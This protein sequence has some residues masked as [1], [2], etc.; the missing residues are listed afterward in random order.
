MKFKNKVVL[1]TGGG[2]GIGQETAYLYAAQGGKVVIA[3]INEKGSK[4]TVQHIKDNGGVAFFIKTNVADADQVKSL[5]DTI[6]VK[7]GRLDIAINNAGIGGDM[8]RTHEASLEDWDK[9]MAVNTSGVFYCM[10]YELQ[11]M[12]AQGGGAIVN[13]ASVAGLKGLPN[14]VAYTASK[15]AVVGMTKTVAVEYAR[16]NIRVNAICPVFT[17]TALFQPEVFDQYKPGISDKLK[18]SIPMKRF[19]K[20]SETAEAILWLTSDASSFI[21]GHALPVD[22][23]LMA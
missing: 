8:A 23:G 16:K 6:A 7:F 2:S 21:T 20:A 14:S 13:I 1:V 18:G 5:M 4:E 22:G 3:D 17:E 11:Q 9:V 12:L 10:K 15:H 19:G